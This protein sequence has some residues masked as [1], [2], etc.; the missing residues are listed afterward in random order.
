MLNRPD[1][2]AAGVPREGAA[3]IIRG[4][5]DDV[6]CP[7]CWW[8]NHVSIACVCA[9]NRELLGTRRDAVRELP[10]RVGQVY[11]GDA[12]EVR[13]TQ[14]TVKDGVAYAYCASKVGE[15]S[16]PLRRLCPPLYRLVHLAPSQRASV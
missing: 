4:Q 3:T 15:L 14:L 2:E 13:V 8:W 16:V 9:H 6:W 12:G 7:E 11:E 5:L 1:D 10:V